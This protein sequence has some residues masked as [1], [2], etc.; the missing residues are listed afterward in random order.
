M[1]HY[2][3]MFDWATDGNFHSEVIGVG[4]TL[5]EAKSLLNQR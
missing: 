5:E 1:K 2:V 3:V 4:H